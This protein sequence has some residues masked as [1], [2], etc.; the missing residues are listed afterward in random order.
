[1]TFRK[2]LLFCIFSTIYTFTFSQTNLS[3]GWK[4][5]LANDYPLAEEAFKAELEQDSLNKDA[6][7]GMIFLSEA[8]ENPYDFEKYI[9]RHIRTYWEPEMIRLFN[10]T[11]D[12][13]K[14]I[15][16]NDTL[17]IEL[18]IKHLVD[19]WLDYGE[20]N[21]DINKAIKE[22]RKYTPKY[23][24]SLLGPFTSNSGSGYEKTY[25]VETSKFD[26]TAL[27]KDKT[28]LEYYWVTPKYMA[29]SGRIF[30][31]NHL[32]ECNENE[33]YFANT[34]FF[35]PEKRVV[36]IRLTRSSP[37]KVWLDDCLILHDNDG[38]AYEYD[39]EIIEVELTKG[40]HRFLLK[41]ANY[42]PLE[43]TY[44][45]LNYKEKSLSNQ[46]LFTV[47]ITDKEG[48]LFTDITSSKYAEYTPT[49]YNITVT[50]ND[51][52]TSIKNRIANGA[53]HPFDYYLLNRAYI[54]ANKTLEGE[55]KF[56]AIQ[57]ENPTS[58]Y[59]KHLLA[60]M[61]ANSGKIEKVYPLLKDFDYD[62]TPIF[63]IMW[64]KHKE[65]NKKFEEEKYLASLLKLHALSP[66]NYT[67]NN[68]LINYYEQE[69][70]KQLQDSL[71][72]A[73]IA[74]YPSYEYSY[75]YKLSDYKSD[76]RYSSYEKDDDI[77]RYKKKIKTEYDSY[78]YRYIIKHYIAKGKTSKVIELYDELI[79]YEP[80]DA[81]N[82]EDKADFLFDEEMYDEAIIEINKAI[83]LKPFDDDFYET[84]GDIYEKKE[85]LD[86]AIVNYK[87]A[88][89]YNTSYYTNSIN[90]KIE[91]IE[92]NTSYKDFFKTK[93]FDDILEESKWKEL[94]TNE[95]DLV[96]MYTKDVVLSEANNVE[97][98]SKMLVKILTDAGANKWTEQN[99]GFLGDLNVSK[100]IK[101]DGTEQ[102]P[103][104]S[105][106]YIVF[107]NLEAGDMIMLEGTAEYKSQ[108][109]FDD[110][111]INFFT[112]RFDSPI[113]YSKFEVAIPDYR[114]LNVANH[115]FKTE[116]DTFVENN[117][118]H[119]RWEFHN[120]PAVE[121]EEAIL[122]TY[123]KYP[124]LLL[125][126]MPDW[127]K[128]A[129]WYLDKTYRRLEI[130]YNVKEVLDTIITNEMTDQEK[131]IAIYNYITKK[132]KYSYV[133]FLNSRF[134]PKYSGNTCSA[135][136][137]DCKDVATLM[138][139]MLRELN[140]ESYYVLV[141]T[142]D[143][144]NLP[145]APTL[146]FNHVIVGYKIDSVMQY[147]DLTTDFYPYYVL[148]EM[149]AGATALV[150]KE[151]TKDIFLLPQDD[152]LPNKTMI[153][154]TATANVNLDRS[155]T[156][157]VDAKYSGVAGGDL[158]E[159][160]YR[161]PLFKQKD[162]INEQIGES[163]FNNKQIDTLSFNK[164][165]EITSPLE[166]NFKV[167]SSKYTDK[168]SNLFILQIPYIIS[169]KPQNAIST[170]KRSNR[171][172]LDDLIQVSPSTQKIYMNFPTGYKLTELPEDIS[173]SSKFGT[174]SIHYEY[175]KNGG[176]L[177]EK[178]Q[179]FAKNVIDTEEFEEFREFYFK[180][181]DADRQKIAIQRKSIR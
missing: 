165:K 4:Q 113:Y 95:D 119:Y 11:F 169:I 8:K 28:G 79:E 125:S 146:M 53:N 145:L 159:V 129:N 24:W 114:T 148:P 132:L 101:N 122:D 130:P 27:Y 10:S 99:F 123:D 164:L 7:E 47:R 38:I 180:I 111:F 161:T 41:D 22:L 51:V 168:I 39:S 120:I 59:Y 86:S 78:A 56:I 61:Y 167:S 30:F 76:S 49:T 149:D 32:E 127:S 128:V 162:V 157:D 151:D 26:T 80:Y 155:I 106:G 6:I 58:N 174:Y 152:V 116:L 63:Q 12:N 153:N 45:L 46:G 104:Q 160:L 17:P 31:E 19:Y 91:K 179:I 65:I 36:Q 181:L 139:T 108:S 126:T 72:N 97:V 137:G 100:V 103:D 25:E 66:S 73:I 85:M 3:E 150:I 88:R 156:I 110:E 96:L 93:S 135:Q 81:D 55:E 34:F 9:E 33:V 35:V 44:T 173:I 20:K 170:E 147:A 171:L 52:L 74:A 102:I 158:R 77:K 115:K 23:T 87:K 18:R 117:I 109:L 43:D 40:W 21:K 69:N 124:H 64:D 67:A 94:Q 143:Y 89:L 163:V 62:K 14:E 71:I 141:R 54:Y 84:L 1:M 98:F 175:T 16:D 13:K 105:R 2:I 60:K 121:R 68:A 83:Q 15:A 177:V 172:K 142:N 50:K 133:D 70:L 75:K 92:G 57:K 48:V 82:Y 5:I 136:I 90:K 178:K 29:H 131:V 42:T 107:K 166:A 144:N 140:I 37:A 138:I 176:L 112:Y 154:I 134:T 118:R